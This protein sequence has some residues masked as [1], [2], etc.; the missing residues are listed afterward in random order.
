M[1]IQT[2]RRSVFCPNLRGFA[3][4]Q[5][6]AGDSPYIGC[7]TGGISQSRNEEHFLKIGEGQKLWAA[8]SAK[9]V[10]PIALNAR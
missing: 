8:N 4:F 5:V 2:M 7:A 9:P 10:L 3:L 6:S 1:Q